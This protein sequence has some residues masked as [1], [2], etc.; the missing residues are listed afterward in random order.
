MPETFAAHAKLMFDLQVLAFQ[1]DMTRVITFMLGREFGSRNYREIGIPEGHHT[2][3]HH[4][5]KQVQIDKVIKID[6]FQEQMFAY[7]IDRLKSTPDGDGTLL[8][9]MAVLQGGGISNGNEHLHNNL[10]TLLVGGANGRIKG[11]RHVRFPET[12]PITNLHLTLLDMIGVP[13]DTLGD[14]N[15]QLDLLAV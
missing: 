12:T 5:N 11:G 14:S 1:T 3:T 2:V 6:L 7:Y 13:C 10:P 8:D 15:G 9:H 4:Q